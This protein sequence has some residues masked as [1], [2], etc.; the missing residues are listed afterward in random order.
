MTP[1]RTLILLALI[2][3]ALSAP[4]LARDLEPGLRLVHTAAP[5]EIAL[6]FD[7]CSGAV[8]HRILDLLVAERIPATFFV[9]ARWLKRNAEALAVIRA[10]GNLFEIENHGARH[11]PAVTDEAKVFG[12]V[13]AG[14][15]E[16]VRAEVEGGS[17][18]I[19]LSTGATPHWFRGATARYSADAVEAIE[20]KGLKIAGY[21]LNADVGASLS[22]A[23]TEKRLRAAKNGDVV[24]AHINQPTHA[25]GAGIAAGLLALKQ[26][27]ASFVRL[28]DAE[29]EASG[30]GHATLPGK[31]PAF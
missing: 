2:P 11:I 14:T 7:A 25:A 19:R 6:T 20:A 29:S 5:R 13:T 31:T 26:A 1:F 18:A 15:L 16:A 17:E 28:D 23:A 4:V 8:D 22:A 30:L 3:S 21:S 24:I 9:T 10:H 12:L 27:G